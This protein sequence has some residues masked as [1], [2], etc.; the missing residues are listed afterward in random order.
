M[1]S[2]GNITVTAPFGPGDASVASVFNDVRSLTYDFPADMIYITRK[3]GR[4]FE[5][6]LNTVA[7]ISQTLSGNT[8]PVVIST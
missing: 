5:F 2:I 1:A 3:D 8:W 4:V 7:T 6:D